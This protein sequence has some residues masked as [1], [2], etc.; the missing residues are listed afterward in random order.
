VEG[1]GMIR[2]VNVKAMTVRIAHEPMPALKWPAMTMD[3]KVADP[4]LLAN[5]KVG[6]KVRFTLQ[7]RTVTAI[8]PG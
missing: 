7:G 4:Q 6:A 8:S 1:V 5:A 3:F 2:S